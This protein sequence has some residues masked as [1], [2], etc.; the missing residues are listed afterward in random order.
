MSTVLIVLG[1]VGLYMGFGLFAA[2]DFLRYAR[3]PKNEQRLDLVGEVL[4]CAFVVIA[5]GYIAALHAAKSRPTV[6]ERAY[7]SAAR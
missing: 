3:D 1:C 7:A 4:G 6:T 2:E 5:F